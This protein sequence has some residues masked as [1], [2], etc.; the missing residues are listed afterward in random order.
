MIKEAIEGGECR[1]SILC[2]EKTREVET[3]L[4]YWKWIWGH[5][6]GSETVLQ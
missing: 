6:H 4:K 5:T 2:A 3:G 1:C